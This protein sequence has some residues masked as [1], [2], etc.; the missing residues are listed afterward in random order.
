MSTLREC[1]EELQIRFE[2]KEAIYV[3]KGALRVRVTK[4]GLGLQRSI[5]A[6]VEEVPTPGLPT[7]IFLVRP[8]GGRT[9]LRWQIGTSYLTTFSEHCWYAGYGGWSRFFDPRIIRG[10]IDLASR[11]SDNATGYERYDQVIFF[12]M[13]HAAYEAV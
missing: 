9:P 10:V 11:F 12:L 3:E 4:I 13:D 8:W 5:S 7:G 1:I 2:G 6:E